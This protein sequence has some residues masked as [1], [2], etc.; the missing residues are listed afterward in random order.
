MWSAFRASNTLLITVVFGA[1][2]VLNI[3]VWLM[4]KYIEASHDAIPIH[5]LNN[6]A[7]YG[8]H[9]VI[10]HSSNL[11]IIQRKFQLVKLM[12]VRLPKS[13]DRDVELV[14]YTAKGF[15]I[16]YLHVYHFTKLIVS[17]IQPHSRC[18]NIICGICNE[19]HGAHA[20]FVPILIEVCVTSAN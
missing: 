18:L 14:C 7:K 2:L 13:S 5:F 11:F 19:F 6:N 9:R 15:I 12:T 4:W 1:C 17:D 8:S 16:V 3:T 10:T 20:C